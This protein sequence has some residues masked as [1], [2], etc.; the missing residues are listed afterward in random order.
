MISE[1][2]LHCTGIGPVRLAQLHEAGVR[3]WSDVVGCGEQLPVRYAA[4]LI[5]ESR[6]CLNAL[7]TRDIRYFVDRFS[8]F[9]KW[10]IVA[11]FLDEMS[12]FDIETM[13]LEHNSPITVI[14]CWHRG[15]VKTFVEHENL[16]DF[17]HLLDDVTLL[18]SFNG[19]SFDVPR[20][21]D[22]FHIPDLPCPHLDLRWPCYHKG[23]KGSLKS[24]TAR[25][26]FTRPVD[27]QD[28]DGELAIHLWNR[29]TLD[30]DHRARA[31][32][33][34]YCASDVVLLAMLAHRLAERRI[35][36][37]V[38]WWGQLPTTSLT[39]QPCKTTPAPLPLTRNAFGEG[40]PS[41]LRARR[42]RT[43]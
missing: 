4:P 7:E 31:L 17:L 36:S 10:R 19:S 18:A 8:P 2:L 35:E 43:A 29:W 30:Q 42:I 26:G 1:A 33:V 41:K 21:L 25:L 27:L 20:V 28:A 32:L 9:D 16:D 38:A 15:E 11:E 34:R 12:F 5:E 37:P 22:T 39:E 6:R 24:I 3:S 14:A 13:G 40:S 23:F